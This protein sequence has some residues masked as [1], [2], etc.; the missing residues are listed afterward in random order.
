MLKEM[1]LQEIAIYFVPLLI[2][3]SVFYLCWRLNLSGVDLVN[4]YADK[5]RASLFAGFL[6]LGSF[7]LALK[8]GIVIKIKEGVYDQAV[9]R[10]K[11]QGAVELSGK[12]IYGPLRRLSRVLSVAVFSALATSAIQLTLGLVSQWWA[13]TLCLCIASF[14]LL[15]LMMAFVLIQINLSTWFDLMEDGVKPKSPDAQE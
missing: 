15:T 12:T 13:S 2:S 7:L 14:S 4:F 1:T 11:V 8:T 10:E 3:G 6:T 9:Y 5:M